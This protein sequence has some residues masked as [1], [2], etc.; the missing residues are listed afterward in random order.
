MKTPSIVEVIFFS[1]AF[2]PFAAC[3]PKQTDLSLIEQA[4]ANFVLFSSGVL[5]FAAP[6]QSLAN[7]FLPLSS[8]FIVLLP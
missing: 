2:S 8:L 5:T 6:Y 3:A 1:I 7:I 4:F